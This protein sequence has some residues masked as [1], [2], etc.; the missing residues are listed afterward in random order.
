LLEIGLPNPSSG[1]DNLE[2]SW[3]DTQPNRMLDSSTLDQVLEQSTFSDLQ[4]TKRVRSRLLHLAKLVDDGVLGKLTSGEEYDGMVGEGLRTELPFNYLVKSDHKLTRSIWTP[5]GNVQVAEVG[6]VR[7]TFDGRADLV[8]ALRDNEGNGWLQV[9]DAKTT[10]CLSGYNSKSP[11]EGHPLQRDQGQKS[12]HAQSEAEYEILAHHRLQLA[13][14][15][16]ALEENEKMKPKELR[17]RIL[18]PAILV[19]ASG[20][21][22]RMRD[23]DYEEAKSNLIDLISWMGYISAVEEGHEPPECS[24]PETCKSCKLVGKSII[25]DQSNALPFQA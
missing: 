21:M 7:T 6:E 2:P 10:G 12:P 18:P 17:R 9:V 11:S 14:Y 23:E 4:L 22:I 3:T 1:C 5:S 25:L 13:L 19:A 24:D 15:C 8:L 16:L 20:R